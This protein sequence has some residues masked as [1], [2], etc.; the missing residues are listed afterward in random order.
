M[1]PADRNPDVSPRPIDVFELGTPFD[2][3]HGPADLEGSVGAGAPLLVVAVFERLPRRQES[4]TGAR[5]RT[6]GTVRIQ[7][8]IVG[9]DESEAFA[10]AVRGADSTAAVS[11]CI[12]TN[13]T[14]APAGA[15]PVAAG[16][17]VSPRSKRRRRWKT[18]QKADEL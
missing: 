5:D 4:S 2:V 6:S 13:E 16:S 14:T 1:L 9:M 3:A 7:L 18:R 15:I 8:G 12:I 11:E 17:P 10:P